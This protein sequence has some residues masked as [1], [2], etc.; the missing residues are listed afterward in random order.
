MSLSTTTLANLAVIAGFDHVTKESDHIVASVRPA[1]GVNSVLVN[2]PNVNM[3]ETEPPVDDMVEY[4]IPAEADYSLTY[5]L[6]LDGFNDSIRLSDCYKIADLKSNKFRYFRFDPTLLEC[7]EEAS[8]HYT[9]CIAV[10][11]GS[12][13]R[14]RSENNRN[15]D[16]RH[17]EEKWRFSVG[18]AVEIGKG[19]TLEELKVLG[20]TVIRSCVQNLIRKRLILG[21]GA[22]K[23]KLY[24]DIRESSPAAEFVKVWEDG[25]S[26]LY[27]YLKDIEN[28]F[29][30]GN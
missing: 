21:I 18:Q 24:V 1:T 17:S 22:H 15:I 6:L 3:H 25:S 4:E 30:N 13:Y 27:T 29:K 2:Y 7:M 12:G 11:S 19:K 16:S 23:D 9:E 28:G 26:D 8:S 10:E 20:L 5:P 14:V